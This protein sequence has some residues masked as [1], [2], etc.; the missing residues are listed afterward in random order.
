MHCFILA[1]VYSYIINIVHQFMLLIRD[2][3]KKCSFKLKSLRSSKWTGGN[4]VPQLYLLSSLPSNRKV[5]FMTIFPKLC[6]DRNRWCRLRE[7]FRKPT[8]TAL[9]S[10]SP[11]FQIINLIF[12]CICIWLV[13]RLGL[14]GGRLGRGG[15]IFDLCS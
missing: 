15:L 5:W 12:W 7:C 2:L 9:M 8:K 6:G 1:I 14:L 13:W 10:K 4:D 3:I 11:R